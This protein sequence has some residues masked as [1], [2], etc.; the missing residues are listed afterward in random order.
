MSLRTPAP[1]KNNAAASSTPVESLAE[2]TWNL[3]DNVTALGVFLAA[4]ALRLVYW[5]G[6][7]KEVWFINP[8]ID[9]DHYHKW[10]LSIL[11][12]DFLGAGTFAHGPLYA[13]LLAGV[14]ALVGPDPSRAAGIQLFFGAVCCALIFLL[15]RRFFSR[16]VALAAGLAQALYGLAF[17][18]EGTLL[19][20]VLINFLNLL[21]LLSTY[22]A[23]QRPSAKRWILPGVF[24]GLSFLARPSI[25]LFLLVLLGW[26]VWLYGKNQRKLLAQCSAALIAAMVVMVAPATVRNAVVL[27]EW[28]I[29]VPHGGMN[30]YIGN[31]KQAKGY[32]V[33]LDNNAGLNADK[34]AERFKQD[35]EAALGRKLSFSESNNYWYGKAWKEI[36]DDLGHWQEVLLNKFL[37]FFNNYEY[38]TSLNYYA[39]RDFTPFLHKPWLEFKWVLPLALIGM[40]WPRKR[41]W[42][43]FPLLGFVVVILA[44]N[45]MIM[46]SSEYRYAVMPVF[47]IF[48]AHG[49]GELVNWIRER[50]WWRLGAA[51]ALV[52]MFFALANMDLVSKNERDYH[53]ASA[54]S[55]F[56]HLLMR[57]DN[58]QGA[59]EEYGMAK[60]LVK[61]QPQ[62][63]SAA[64][65]ELA[66]T[67]MRLERWDDA[68]KELE[69]AYTLT[70]D[71]ISIV[72]DLATV[73]TAQGR[74]EE[75]IRLRKQ[76]LELDRRQAKLHLNLGMT[77]LWAG[78]DREA[79]QAF[80]AAE[81]IS[82][83]LKKFIDEK[84]ALVLRDRK[85]V[86]R[87]K[88]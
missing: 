74:F 9:S 47:F 1:S 48:A 56:G 14:Y 46:V 36:F 30:F 29:S 17:F 18:H 4:L 72:D 38:T 19:T 50:S 52:L 2:V 31:S 8:I 25:G 86:G 75:A 71:E 76:A 10:A 44:G 41:F 63:L 23:A 37:L 67:Y 70:P 80:A 15:A 58:A 11:H 5:L 35:A 24:L 34:I 79:E 12:G 51:L 54:H 88:H 43:I 28:L 40:I 78:Q 60:D 66:N 85:P 3:W 26:L 73:A 42:D 20:V 64:S 49:G 65:E 61:F 16:P 45:V 81:Q 27:H 57:L 7:R 82:P 6:V 13:Y 39:V 69:E 22:W 59:S 83:G 53:M 21:L 62:Y 55:N 87:A 77:C 84:R 33:I 68:R 32:H